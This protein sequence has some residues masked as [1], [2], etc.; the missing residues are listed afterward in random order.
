MMSGKI[1]ISKKILKKLRTICRK[2][3]TICFDFNYALLNRMP[4]SVGRARG[5]RILVYHGICDE[6]PWRFNA[7]YL[8]LKQFEEHLQLISRHYHP[9]SLKDVLSGNLSVDKLNVLLTFDDGLKNN[10]THAFPLLKKYKVPA[11]FFVTAAA[12]TS[13]PFLFNDLTDVAPLLISGSINIEGEHFQR[14]KIFLN[15]R[16]VNKDGI[17]LAHYFHKASQGTRARV[18]ETLLKNIPESQLAKHTLY[19]ELMN[20]AEL[21]EISNHPDYEIG[22]HGFYHTDLSTLSEQELNE[23]LQRSQQYLKHVLGKDIRSIAFP[24]GHYNQAVIDACEKHGFH[25]LFRTEKDMAVSTKA[26]LFERFTVNPFV[27]ALNQLY[28]IAKTK[29]E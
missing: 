27:S 20:E 12:S 8:S 4:K 17:Q 23:E 26:L 2:A 3:R 19:Y 24:Y 18:L 28:Y 25:Y 14:K 16:L 9:V 15:Q 22:A 11:V 5:L 10:F 6:Q 29:Y 13:Q 7:R 21:R 1:S